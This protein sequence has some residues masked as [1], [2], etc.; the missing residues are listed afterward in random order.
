MV[1]T[2][3]S[4]KLPELF[5]PAIK[6]A[7]DGFSM[8][9]FN[10]EEFN[11][12]GSRLSRHE[13]AGARLAQ[14]LHRRYR[15]GRHAEA[16]RRAEASPDLARCTFEA[17]A[18]EGPK[19][20][21]G[22]ALGQ[23]LIDRLTELGGVLTM[24]DLRDVR[25]EWLDPVSA[26]YRGRT[27]HVPPPPCRSFQYLPSL[28]V[29]SKASTWRR[30]RATASSISTTLC[31]APSAS[32]Q[33]AAHPH[34]HPHSKQK[35]AE[36]LSGQLCRG[37]ARTRARQESRSPA[38]PSSGRP[39]SPKATTSFCDRRRRGQHGVCHPEP[40]RRVRVGCGGRRAPASA[41]TT[42]STGRTSIPRAPTARR[43]ATSCRSAVA[44]SIVTQKDGGTPVLALGTRR[45]LRHPADPAASLRAIHRLR[46]AAAAGDRGT[47]RPTH[48]RPRRAAGVE[49]R[50]QSP[51]RA[52]RAR[53]W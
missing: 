3:G 42:S 22:G 46:H 20:L 33:A 19:L 7:R 34:R 13:H 52:A 48:R 43:S 25:I 36:L 12:G 47:A 51:C 29:S 49:G 41:A 40:R 28:T 11:G 30:C 14:Q 18:T 24:D 15:G 8:I 39:T 17:I 2:Y 38:R 9:E 4:K 35:L 23:K 21:Y 1:S 26:E 50:R 53:P 16:R 31:S 10:V 44:P 45:Q 27:V 5:A 37:L 32:P 6:L